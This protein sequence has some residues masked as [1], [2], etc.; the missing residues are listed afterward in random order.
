MISLL[1]TRYKSIDGSIW[2]KP[3]LIKQEN[4]AVIEQFLDA[5]YEVDHPIRSIE[6]FRMEEDSND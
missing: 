4:K 3:V 2:E 6:G 5:L 1:Y